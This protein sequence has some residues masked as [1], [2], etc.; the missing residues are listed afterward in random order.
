MSAVSMAMSVP[1]PIAMPTSACASAGESF[2]PS[3]TIATTSPASCNSLTWSAF[4]PGS[5]SAYTVSMPTVCAIVA[6]VRLLSPVIIA[7]R[8]PIDLSAHTAAAAEGLGTSMTATTAT[9]A[10]SIAQNRPV[11]P[12][13][14][15]ADSSSSPCCGT[16]HLLR[17]IHARLPASTTDVPTRQRIPHPGT[18]SKSCAG[19]GNCIRVFPRA[20]K[21]ARA[22]AAT[23]TPTGCSLHSS[24]APTIS[25]KR[26][27]RAFSDCAR[28]SVAHSSGL[29]GIISPPTP[30]ETVIP[31]SAKSL[32]SVTCGFPAVSVPVLSNTTIVTLCARSSGSPPLMSMPFLAPTPVPTITAVGVARPRAHGHA[33]TSIEIA[34][35]SECRKGVDISGTETVPVVVRIIQTTKVTTAIVMIAGTKR[36]DI[37]SA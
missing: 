6:A 1:L 12:S 37:L 19:T 28:S 29:S 11:F 30:M 7:T 8:M 16:T 25:K 15:S 5:T 10:P 26:R 27:R 20:R 33:I 31:S 32:H 2:M 35:K 17:S 3:P 21:P 18:A 34:N 24:A 36:A 4:C 14:S 23:A 13:H 9:T 22:K